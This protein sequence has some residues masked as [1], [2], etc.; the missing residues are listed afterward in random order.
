MK[1]YTDKENLIFYAAIVIIFITYGP[2]LLDFL[3][4]NG[5]DVSIRASTTLRNYGPGGILNASE[6]GWHA[7]ENPVYPQVIEFNFKTEKTIKEIGF[8]PQKDNASRGPK[9]V[10]ILVSKDGLKWQQAAVIDNACSSDSD[11]WKYFN[12]IE[13]V[14]IRALRVVIESNCEDKKFLTLRGI[15]FR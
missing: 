4:Q 10:K 6:P 5:A 15:V 9:L 2:V 14:D 11:Q 13:S 3:R 8:L 12:V 7:E 1:N